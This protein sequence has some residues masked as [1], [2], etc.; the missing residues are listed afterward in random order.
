MVINYKKIIIAAA[1]PLVYS[2]LG[3]TGITLKIGFDEDKN[4]V[5]CS[6]RNINLQMQER[7]R[8]F[9][10][11]FFFVMALLSEHKHAPHSPWF[12]TAQYRDIFQHFWVKRHW[13]EVV[14]AAITP[15]WCIAG[16]GLLAYIFEDRWIWRLQLCNQLES[17][18]MLILMLKQFTNVSRTSSSS[19]LRPLSSK[20][21]HLF[22]IWHL[23]LLL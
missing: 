6:I 20:I 12:L 11:C 23:S 5:Q 16:S 10:S 8:C 18:K 1:I 14:M 19:A 22:Y 21:G 3:L 7:A 15:G 2:K 13:S 17:T 9:S 4:R